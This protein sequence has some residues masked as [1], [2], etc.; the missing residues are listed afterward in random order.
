MASALFS[1]LSRD[2]AE[3]HETP[4]PGVAVFTDD[5]NILKFCLVLTPP[6]GPWKDLSLHFDVEI[7]ERWPASPPKVKTSVVGMNHP[8]FFG[9]YICCDLL[10][11][12]EWLEK[13]YTGG[14]TPALTL[15]GLF[16]QFLT[17][18]SS[19]RVEQ[20]YGGSYE[21]GDYM[22]RQFVR[23]ADIP[24]H[25]SLTSR[26]L[27]CST[28]QIVQEEFLKAWQS[29]K[30]R[31]IVVEIYK[32]SSDQVTH[33]VKSPHP[34]DKRIHLFEY[35]NPRWAQTHNLIRTYRCRRCPYGSNELPHH[36]ESTPVVKRVR[37]SNP[38]MQP[39]RRCLLGNLNDD[40]LS[41]V[42]SN[43]PSESVISFS[44][45]Y[46]RMAQLADALHTLLQRELQCFFLRTPLHEC[47]LGIG[48]Q[49][50]AGPRTFS[51]DF[52]WISETAFDV[53]GIRKSIQKR[54]FNYFLP[55]AFSQAHFAR[56]VPQIWTRLVEMD[57]AVRQ[58]TAALNA[59]SRHNGN[60]T[61]APPTQMHQ[62]VGVIYRMMNNIVVSLMKSCDDALEGGRNGSS[63]QLLFASEKAVIAYCHL[64]HLLICLSRKDPR[65]LKDATARLQL[66]NQDAKYR[67]KDH[68][69]DLGE[70]IVLVTLAIALP[71]GTH[72]QK[73]LTWDTI[74]GPFLQ[75]TIV[76]NARWV[77]KDQPDLEIL[78]PT[79]SDYRLHWTF[80]RSKTSLRLMM[81][82]ITFLD[83]FINTY[84]SGTGLGLA[85]LDDNYGFAEKELPER[86][87][88]EI[89]AIYEVGTWPKFFQRVRYARG[90]SLGKER[91][92]QMLRDAI[93]LSGQRGYHNPKRERDVGFLRTQRTQNE[94]QWLQAQ[95]AR[96]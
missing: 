18:F 55:L 19:T 15:R 64:F 40:V 35:R 26:H 79:P 65:I 37:V 61:V 16:L 90:V 57:R 28:T 39:P 67:T 69:P 87:V 49:F 58:A 8:N 44:K 31:E 29:N 72:D 43:L 21:I 33:K 27:H 60:R 11:E 66:F 5:A 17:F 13:G 95:A 23:E 48:V 6:S 41:V 30:A 9:D 81:F 91:F 63:A 7:P 96:K 46:S 56:A 71:L 59:R 86:M 85:R 62:T 42:V 34:N 32:A 82:Q 94:R 25:A 77:L 45:A 68:N 53:H 84:A 20:D 88:K 22:I 73:Q 14:Y 36:R 38:L 50:D 54:E 76:R 4:Y 92:S 3:L 70:L 75:E 74:N 51:S 52:D 24:R 78:E 1:R 12:Q 89:K 47:I 2:L 10:K 83:M 93:V 80:E